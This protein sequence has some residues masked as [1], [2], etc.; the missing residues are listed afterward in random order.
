M[1]M[2]ILKEIVKAI[3]ITGQNPLM[4]REDHKVITEVRVEIDTDQLAERGHIKILQVET[5]TDL[6]NK[7]KVITTMAATGIIKIPVLTSQATKSRLNM[8][9]IWL[10]YTFINV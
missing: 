2:I 5:R 9:K 6:V 4:I 8:G 10:L 7:R 1:Y 3:E